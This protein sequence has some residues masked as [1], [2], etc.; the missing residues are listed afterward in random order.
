[1][2]PLIKSQL[3][4][5][6]PDFRSSA[7][8]C[9][10]ASA[11]RVGVIRPRA[12]HVVERVGLRRDGGSAGQEAGVFERLDI[13]QV[14]QRAEPEHGQ[15]AMGGDIGQRGSERRHPGS[16][17]D[18]IE[19][20]QPGDGVSAHLFAQEARELGPCHRLQVGDRRDDEVFGRREGRRARL[21]ADTAGGADGVGVGWPGAMVPAAGNEGELVGPRAQLVLD[22]GDERVE[23]ALGPDER[24]ERLALW[25]RGARP[26]RGQ[27]LRHLAAD[28]VLRRSM[29]AP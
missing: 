27:H 24:R 8:A 4:R 14:A 7:A 17:A 26:R 3:L 1:M 16:G 9:A 12:E 13:G 5:A 20:L 2:D 15:E 11:L 23:P 29:V 28:H 6:R 19:P 10:A 18:E 22:I 25:R 21:L